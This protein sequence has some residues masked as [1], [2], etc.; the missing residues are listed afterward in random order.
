LRTIQDSGKL[1]LHIRDDILKQTVRCFFPEDMLPQAF[2][3]FRKRVEVSGM[4]HY[5]RNGVPISIDVAQIEP[6]PD[7]TEL[8]SAN[9][10]RGI[11][12]VA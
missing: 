4:V 1:E 6:L 10:V 12:G 9:E 2:E 3:N 5:R 11:L 8:P 7:D